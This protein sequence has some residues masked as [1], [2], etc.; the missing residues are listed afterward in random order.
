MARPADED[1]FQKDRFRCVYCGFDGSTFDGWAFLVV[2]HF[3]PRSRG[4]SDDIGN[5]MTACVICNSMKGDNDWLTLDEA[6]SNL[7]QWRGQM[8]TYWQTKVQPLV[9]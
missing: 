3:K 7:R 1:V 5:L 6:K 4:G 8:R 9:R 2:D